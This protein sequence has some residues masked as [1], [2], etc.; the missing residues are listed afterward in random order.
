MLRGGRV[1]TPIGALPARPGT[2]LARGPVEVLLRPEGLLVQ[3][4]GGA[5]A[6]VEACR[7]LGATTLV[8]LAVADGAG[9][10]LHLHARLPPESASHVDS[11]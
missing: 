11:G 6:E 9:G 5:L 1:E 7:L 2:D 4:E 3:A 10:V 8:H